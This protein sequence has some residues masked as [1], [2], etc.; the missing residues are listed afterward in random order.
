MKHASD[1]PILVTGGAGHVGANL[2]HRLVED[3]HRV[4]VLLRAGEN[5]ESVQ[6]LDV[7]S[8]IGDLRDPT[9]LREAVKGCRRVF[10][11]ASMVST[12]DGDADHRRAIYETNVVGTR[13]LLRAAREHSVEKFVLTSSFSAVG[14]DL[15]ETDQPAHEGMGFYPFHRAMP[16]ERTKVLQE[17][18]VL[19]LSHIHS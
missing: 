4:R 7:E 1:A 16:Y 3:G 19:K 5:N 11:V 8:A 9:S 14:Y 6:G 13:H 2:V 10:H 15:D 18:E 17:H 12:I